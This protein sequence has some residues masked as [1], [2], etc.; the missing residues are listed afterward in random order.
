MSL[1]YNDLTLLRYIQKRQM[2]P[3]SKTALHFQKNESSIRRTIEQINLYSS[4]PM[5]RIE[6]SICYSC[7]SYEDL[8]SFIRNLDQK[9]YLSSSDERIRVM[10]TAIFFQNY[11]NSSKLYEQW[12]LSLTTKKQD[13]ALL[14]QFLTRYGLELVTKKKKG[15][16]IQGDELQLRFLVID[17]LHP[18]FE[19]TSENK[20]LARFANTPLEKQTYE[21]ATE[22]L[23]CKFS[24]SN[25][26]S[27]PFS[28][29]NRLVPKLS[30]QKIPAAFYLYYE[31]TDCKR[32]ICLLLQTAFGSF[33]HPFYR[34]SPAEPA[35]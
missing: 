6:K 18:L 10:I 27:F 11:V 16:S 24:G 31:N 21:L 29:R 34:L 9:D 22:Y 20:V 17:I 15:L 12:G 7:I 32:Y 33:K 26:N 25:R 1:S 30:L 3:L 19:F 8:V 4:E 13:T 14:R 5:V 2:I 23:S 28:L 35:L